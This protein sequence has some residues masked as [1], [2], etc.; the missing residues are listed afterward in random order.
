MTEIIVLYMMN[1]VYEFVS[2]LLCLSL[3]VASE[4][5]HFTCFDLIVYNIVL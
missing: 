2:N 1:D 3:N 5:E 4:N